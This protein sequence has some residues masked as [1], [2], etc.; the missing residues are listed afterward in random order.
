MYSNKV[1]I[2]KI[3]QRHAK[4]RFSAAQKEYE[5]AQKEFND[6]FALYREAALADGWC[7]FCDPP[8]P[9]ERCPGHTGYAAED[10]IA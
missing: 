3:K 10:V 5:K 7:P 8:V 2:L 1:A 6:A 4:E 9:L